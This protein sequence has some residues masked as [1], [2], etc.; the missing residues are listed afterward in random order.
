[1]NPIDEITH[2]ERLEIAANASSYEIQKAYKEI[3]SIY[4]INP[5][6]K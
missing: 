4:D 6:I 2:Y 1:M 3:L 5:A